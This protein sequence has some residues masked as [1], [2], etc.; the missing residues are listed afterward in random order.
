MSWEYKIVFLVADEADEDGYE[1][2]LHESMHMLNTLGSEGWELIGYLPH[3]IQG[4]RNKF[5][6]I[7]KR[8]KGN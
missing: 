5:H 3:Q 1:L 7:M 2:R 6:V 8:L 4:K